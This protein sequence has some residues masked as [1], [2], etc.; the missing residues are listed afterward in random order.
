MQ[1][2]FIAQDKN[3]KHFKNSWNM[4]SKNFI[5]WILY[6]QN[7]FKKKKRKKKLQNIRTP[8]WRG[9]EALRMGRTNLGGSRIHRC[10]A[11]SF[12]YILF[13]FLINTI[14]DPNKKTIIRETP[15]NNTSTNTNRK[16]H[17]NHPSPWELFICSLKVLKRLQISY[18]THEVFMRF[19]FYVGIL[20]F[21]FISHFYSFWILIFEIWKI[22]GGDWNFIKYWAIFIII[23]LQVKNRITC[24][25]LHINFYRPCYHEPTHQTMHISL[26]YQ[27][28]K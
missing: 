19:F 3:R 28:G 10:S 16:P 25:C 6:P 2:L 21:T 14:Y 22:N 24:G 23:R 18:Q 27:W 1:V 5:K 7:F 11:L 4:T 13:L 26:P 15:A 12:G 20:N 9:G 17:Q 8:R